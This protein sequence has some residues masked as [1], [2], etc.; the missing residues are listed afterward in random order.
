MVKVSYQFNLNEA[1]MIAVEA[2]V[3]FMSE[4]YKLDRHNALGL[5]SVVV[6]VRIT[7]MV[8]GTRGVHALLPHKSITELGLVLRS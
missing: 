7:Q 8:N 3:D 5:A 6:D 2:M 4:S 1:A